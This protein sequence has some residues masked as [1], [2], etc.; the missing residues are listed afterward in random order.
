MVQFAFGKINFYMSEPFD[1]SNLEFEEAR[2]CIKD[3]MMLNATL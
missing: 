3:K 1:I 2:N